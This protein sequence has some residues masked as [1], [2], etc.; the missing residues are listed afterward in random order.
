M[1][2]KDREAVVDW[3]SVS[4]WGLADL[5][6]I[7]LGVPDYC[8]AFRA[9]AARDHLDGFRAFRLGTAI[10]L[11]ALSKSFGSS[12]APTWRA[13]STKRLWRS[14]SV[15]FGF[16]AALGIRLSQIQINVRSPPPWLN[17]A[18]GRR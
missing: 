10:F 7:V 17:R 6:L 13:M 11:K 5:N 12:D 15:G 16:R 2:A 8:L 3:P 4:A 9:F 18:S 14:A 1:R